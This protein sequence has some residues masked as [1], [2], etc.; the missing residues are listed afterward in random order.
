[1]AKAAAGMMEHLPI[2]RVTNLSRAIEKLKD[3]GFW[4]V[5]MDG[6]AQ[7]T[8]DKLQKIHI[9]QTGEMRCNL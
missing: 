6:Y 5:G 8:I 9:L 2:A 7:T 4:T 1:V 3:V